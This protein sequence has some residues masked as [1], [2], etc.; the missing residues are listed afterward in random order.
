MNEQEIRSQA[1]IA[2]LNAILA[3]LMHRCA[4]LA[5]ELAVAQAKIAEL[6]K[7]E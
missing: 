3:G 1:F 2:E 7:R 6:E 5:G 4:N